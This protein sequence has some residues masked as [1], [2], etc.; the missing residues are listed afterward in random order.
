MFF[1]ALLLCLAYLINCDQ[2]ELSFTKCR[3]END[4]SMAYQDKFLTYNNKSYFNFKIPDALL[5]IIEKQKLIPYPRVRFVN[6]TTGNFLHFMHLVYKNKL[7]LYF[8]VD[9]ILHPFI[10]NSYDIMS[11]YVDNV[12]IKLIKIFTEKTLKFVIENEHSKDEEIFFGVAYELS[13]EGKGELTYDLKQECAELISNITKSNET[14]VNITL[15]GSN[16]T[17]YPS[18]FVVIDALWKTTTDFMSLYKTVRWFQNFPLDIDNSN[19]FKTILRLGNIIAGSKTQNLYKK[20]KTIYKFFFNE[21]E[22]NYNP[23]DVLENFLNQKTNFRKKPPFDLVK[24]ETRYKY[25]NLSLFFSQ[26]FSFEG[27]LHSNV[28]NG[29]RGRLYSSLFEYISAINHGDLMLDLI[30]KRYSGKVKKGY[31]FRD[32]IDMSKEFNLT[33]KNVEA[34]M[35][36]EREAWISSLPGSINYLLN[37]IGR[38]TKSIGHTY[39]AKL[40]NTLT[41][42]YCHY[43]RDILLL[44]QNL[45]VT[46]AEGEIF[47]LKFEEN[48]DFYTE[49]SEVVN[50]YSKILLDGIKDVEFDVAN[51]KKRIEFYN[52]TLQN[53][54]SKVVKGIK[55]QNGYDEGITMEE[56]KES[57]IYYDKES[58]RYKGWYPSLYEE[59]EGGETN[60]GIDIYLVRYY[61]VPP[62]NEVKF[63]GVAIYGAMSFLEYGIVEFPDFFEEKNKVMIYAGY[64]GNEYPHGYMDKIDF[65]GLKK[66]IVG[67]R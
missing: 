37:L 15:F 27:Y 18:S 51:M 67:R 39:S 42:A 14:K 59:V 22:M 21:F 13:H 12:Y 24:N 8:T 28:L 31:Q 25:N 52:V 47:D 58:G 46:P 10:E 35:K 7:P 60:Y 65:T 55:T 63:K 48:I 30:Y 2:R 3:V 16:R 1:Q 5:P 43:K 41:G 45:N 57:M 20:L 34:S 66:I 61:T 6:K 64:A 54:I 4:F 44:S 50:R 33:R 32:G 56:I 36:N 62:V 29:T 11:D 26:S 38:K 49:L 19:D 23:P 9:Q 40:Y 17:V 53:A